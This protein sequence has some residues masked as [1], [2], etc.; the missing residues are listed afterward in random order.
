MADSSETV[1]I[2]DSKVLWLYDQNEV[3]YNANGGTLNPRSQ[4]CSTCRWFSHGRCHI[5]RDYPAEIVSNGWCNQWAEAPQPKPMEVTI[6][7]AEPATEIGTMEAK[8]SGIFEQAMKVIRHWLGR[9]SPD[10]ELGFKVYGNH[11]MAVY[12]GTFE[13]REGEFFTTK[14]CDEF[15]NRAELGLVDYPV[16]AL[17]HAVNPATMQGAVIGKTKALARIGNL[18][19]AAGE[20]NDDPIAQAAKDYYGNP[21]HARETSL[22]HGFMYDSRY[23]EG[24]TYHRWNTYEITLLPNGAEAFPFTSFE[25]KE[26]GSIMAVSQAAQ[27]YIQ[28]VLGK[29]KAVQAL[30]AYEQQSKELTEL[31]VRHKDFTPVTTDD[32]DVAPVAADEGFKAFVGTILEDHGTLVTLV[33]A[34]DA[35]INTMQKQLNDRDTQIAALQK[36]LAEAPTPASKSDA[37]VVTDAGDTAKAAAE[38]AKKSSAD[39]PFETMFP[40]LVKPA[41]S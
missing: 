15:I 19:L 9:D 28:D 41:S 12:S 16:L 21:R 11:W 5:V 40:G 4:A 17:W 37:T 26:R 1:E 25:V 6:V 13:D 34:L 10:Y 18:M 8:Q 29:E 7:D 38:L 27:K 22:S 36:A 14:G 35:R 30:A 20:F 39:N 31:G 23:K 3:E 24:N 2:A 32:Q 33:K